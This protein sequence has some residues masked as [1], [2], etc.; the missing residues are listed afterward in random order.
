MTQISE[1]E[2]EQRA[3]S[4]ARAQAWRELQ[5]EQQARDA[6][7]AQAIAENARQGQAMIAQLAQRWRVELVPLYTRRADAHLSGNLDDALECETLMRA[8]YNDAGATIDMAARL[9]QQQ[10]ADVVAQLRR[11]AGVPSQ[12]DSLAECPALS[13]VRRVVARGMAS[14][15]IG[16]DGIGHP[17]MKGFI[18]L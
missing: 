16:P 2:I 4:N 11:D 6:A 18:Q 17:N 7:R 13:P 12:H 1:H 15:L 3:Q 5:Q 10:P 9:L 14:G 8:I